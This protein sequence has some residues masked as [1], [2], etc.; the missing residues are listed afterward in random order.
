V[1]KRHAIQ[2]AVA[3]SRHTSDPSVSRAIVSLYAFHFELIHRSNTKLCQC[4]GRFLSRSAFHKQIR[5]SNTLH[6]HCRKC[7]NIY[8]R[9]RKP[10]RT[11]ERAL[12]VLFLVKYQRIARFVEELLRLRTEWL[13][14]SELAALQVGELRIAQQ[15]SSGDTR[16]DA[17]SHDAGV[18]GLLVDRP[19]QSARQKKRRPARRRGLEKPH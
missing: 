17:W 2:S 3:F 16:L 1:L 9:S 13:T 11:G 5:G 8:R 7:R 19:D 14:P 12:E 10:G 6:S 15:L 4:C 18:F